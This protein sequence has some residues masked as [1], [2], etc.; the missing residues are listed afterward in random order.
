MKKIITIFSIV[1]AATYFVRGFSTHAL[2][3]N[4]PERSMVDA[5]SLAVQTL[6]VTT[7]QFYCVASKIDREWCPVGAWVFTFDKSMMIHKVVYVAMEPF[8]S[9]GAWDGYS[10]PWPLT[11]VR[12]V[13]DLLH[14]TNSIINK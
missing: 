6:G 3:P 9:R 11:E 4:P 1:I 8:N 10:K 14:K 2:L 12:D 13:D 7:N 5:Y